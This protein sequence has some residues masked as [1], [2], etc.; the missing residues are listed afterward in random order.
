[1]IFHWYSM[2]FTRIFHWYSYD[3]P[4]YIPWDSMIFV[5]IPWYSIAIPWYSRSSHD[6]LWYSFIFF[7][8]P[9]YL[10][11][12]VS[13]LCIFVRHSLGS[14][15]TLRALR[16]PWSSQGSPV[17]LLGFPEIPMRFPDSQSYSLHIPLAIF[18]IFHEFAC[19]S[20]VFHCP[21]H[22]ILWYS[23]YLVVF[24]DVPLMFHD[25]PQSFMKSN[26]ILCYSIIFY[27]YSMNHFHVAP[28]HPI[29]RV[30]CALHAVSMQELS[31]IQAW[32]SWGVRVFAYS[33]GIR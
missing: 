23:W 19:P 12:D 26:E 8:I 1:M 27:R 32:C 17:S 4:W 11:Y 25:A 16:D 21:L 31:R 20:V 30:P 3:I 2:I 5:D 14:L 10:F 33:L 9:W 28:W 29:V 18:I 7:D 13:H 15:G 6:I 24:L 22:D